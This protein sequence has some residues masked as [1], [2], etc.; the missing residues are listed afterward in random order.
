[1]TIEINGKQLE[2]KYSFRA[3]MIYENITKKTF[4]PKTVSD[5]VVFF[6]SVV[7]AANKGCE[8]L[9]DDFLDWIDANPDSISMFSKWLEDIFTQQKEI[10][11]TTEV[12]ED[13]AK[14]KKETEEAVEKN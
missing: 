8:L 14:N 11:P 2:L 7:L 12:E 13:L 6:Y 4:N 5:M 1:M 9:F 10:S 3:L